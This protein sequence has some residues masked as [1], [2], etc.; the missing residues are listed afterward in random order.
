M[1]KELLPVSI[2]RNLVDKLYEKRKV[3]YRVSC[4]DSVVDKA[5]RLAR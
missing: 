2:A 3:G 1:E 4:H 5:S